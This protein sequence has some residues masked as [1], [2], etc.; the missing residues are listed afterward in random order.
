MGFG[1]NS[2][3]EDNTSNTGFFRDL[4][5]YD[6]ETN[7]WREV[8][9]LEG[10]SRRQGACGFSIGKYGY[11][12]GGDRIFPVQDWWRYD[13]GKDQWSIIEYS[14]AMAVRTNA[15]V[16]VVGREAYVIGGKIN[17]RTIGNTTWVYYPAE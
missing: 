16:A 12:V 7:T 2:R 8:S 15:S 6:A 3:D 14:S 1:R 11:I 13:P 9:S 4:Y 17:D 10:G 5:E